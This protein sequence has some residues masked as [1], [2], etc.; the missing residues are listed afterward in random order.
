MYLTEACSGSDAL[1][2]EVESLLASDELAQSFLESPPGLA[3]TEVTAGLEGRRI[4]TYQIGSRIGSGGMGEVY[5]AHDTVLNRQVAI[6]VVRP[7]LAQDSESLSRFRRE[8]QVLASLNHPHIAQI[9]G[10]QESDDV[11]ALVM[12]LVSGQTL[13]E[14]IGCGAAVDSHAPAVG[15]PRN[16]PLP[17][18]EALGLAKQIAEALEAAHEQG[19]IH[20]DLKPANIKV[21]EDATVKVLDFGLARALDAAVLHGADASRRPSSAAE[22]T[23]TGDIFGTPAYM[24]PEQARGKPVD[25]RA[26]IWA[27]GCILFELLTG[28]RAFG[29]GS[30]TEV[31][32][33]VQTI[34]PE[35]A[36]LPAKTPAAIRTLL[37]RCLEK[38]RGRRLDS[39]TAVRLEIE[40][41]L[42]APV[43]DPAGVAA[44]VP[45]PVTESR[46]SRH[47]LPR[48]RQPHPLILAGAG[49]LALVTSVAVWEL[50][51]RD[52][53]W[54]NPL[55]GAAVHRVTDFPGEEADAA[56]SPD[57]KFLIFL[58]DRDGPFDAWLTQ[59][60]SGEFT[61]VTKGR[62][63]MMNN[64]NTRML[65]F[66]GDG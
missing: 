24:S 56:I 52:Y 26:D 23:A 66:S 30:A 37:R 31:L 21:R 35:W 60:G 40:D 3:A 4:R 28:Q 9:H 64:P 34:E 5:Q 8:A 14:R 49:A 36:R 43:G 65:G 18:R 16:A 22:A 19:I 20:R 25:R 59:I 54:R 33:A 32:E 42:A 45:G 15:A 46:P 48:R 44:A 11:R 41:A 58:S 6:K 13:A 63:E 51:Q 27:F 17:I 62:F 1:R 29:G 50:W 7:T 57:G 39:A 61:N 12:E 55:T 10:F 2:H 47:D 53:F 38:D